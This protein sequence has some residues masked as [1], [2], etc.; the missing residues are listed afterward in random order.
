MALDICGEKLRNDL[1]TGQLDF[2]VQG[3][4][5]FRNKVI[6][7]KVENGPIL[8]QLNHIAGSV[9]KLSVKVG[10]SVIVYLI[11]KTN[12]NIICWHHIL[13]HVFHK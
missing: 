1:S 12:E 8:D 5:N 10:V 6:F 13:G 11:R 9:M 4:G 7:A 2:N 3:L